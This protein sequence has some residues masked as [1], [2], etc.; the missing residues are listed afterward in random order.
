[1]NIVNYLMTT[2]IYFRISVFQFVK[3]VKSYQQTWV[4]SNIDMYSL[5]NLYRENTTGV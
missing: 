1:M 5:S 4:Y 3:N 2:V